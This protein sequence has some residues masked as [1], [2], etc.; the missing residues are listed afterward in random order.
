MCTACRG[1]PQQCRRQHP[2]GN[3]AKPDALPTPQLFLVVSTAYH[4]IC[5]T[6]GELLMRDTGA[7]VDQDRRTT[8]LGTYLM[9]SNILQDTAYTLQRFVGPQ[10]RPEHMCTYYAGEFVAAANQ[11]GWSALHYI[12]T[13][14][15]PQPNGIA[16]RAVRRVKEGTSCGLMQSVF[17][18]E[19]WAQAMP[20]F[21]FCGTRHGGTET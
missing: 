16:E 12:A 20:C 11:L 7:V 21:C 4:T 8:W 15:R 13:L 17:H 3:I 18:V 6:A 14:Y 2:K 1:Q 19:W 10:S 5:G 9:R